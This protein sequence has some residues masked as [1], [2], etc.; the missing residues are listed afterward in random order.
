MGK[1]A[2]ILFLIFGMVERGDVAR[3][4][5][6]GSDGGLGVGTDLQPAHHAAQKSVPTREAQILA[7]RQCAERK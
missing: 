7:G 4:G 6:L 2:A 3:E 1:C 5:C